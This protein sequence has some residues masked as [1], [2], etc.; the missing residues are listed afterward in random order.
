MTGS[1]T[2]SWARAAGLLLMSASAGCVEESESVPQEEVGPIVEDV[3]VRPDYQIDAK[4]A[5]PI[6]IEPSS[7]SGQSSGADGGAGAGTVVDCTA[8]TR[9]AYNIFANRCVL[10]HVSEG[11]GHGGFGGV[12]SA[13]TLIKTGHVVPFAP[14]RSPVYLRVE[15]GDMPRVGAR[16][17]VVEVGSIGAWINCGAPLFERELRATDGGVADAAPDAGVEVL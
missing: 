16:L 4:V 8:E 14:E 12:L 13:Q 1:R 7:D 5:E 2:A 17:T 9:A 15:S 11:R 3:G 10:C 6:S